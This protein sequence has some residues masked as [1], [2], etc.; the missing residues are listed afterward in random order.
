MS[1]QS[2]SQ[3]QRRELD[4]TRTALLQRLLRQ[5]LER[6]CRMCHHTPLLLLLLLL[7]LLC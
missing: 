2:Q 4:L 1:R 7:L 5:Q 3:E 6:F